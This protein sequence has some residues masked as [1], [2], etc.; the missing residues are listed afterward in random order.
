MMIFDVIIFNV[1]IFNV[2]IFNVIIFNVIIFERNCRGEMLVKH[3]RHK[4]H[5]LDEFCAFVDD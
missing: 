5:W 1:I 4:N 3:E 2:G